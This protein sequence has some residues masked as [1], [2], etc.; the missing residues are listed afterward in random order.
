MLVHF[1]E[2]DIF[3]PEVV[4]VDKTVRILVSWMLPVIH[5]CLLLVGKMS[6][7]IAIVTFIFLQHMLSRRSERR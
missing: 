3:S 2:K 7:K 1:C 5:Q 6:L 4:C